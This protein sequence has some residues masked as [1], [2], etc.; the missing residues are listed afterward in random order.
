MK[1]KSHEPINVDMS[2]SIFPKHFINCIDS[3]IMAGKKRK[4]FL[5]CDIRLE[6]GERL[7]ESNVNHMSK[8][9]GSLERT[10]KN[11]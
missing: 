3:T 7:D 5:F 4:R 11:G 10:R 9:H 1:C 6:K 2:K 8:R